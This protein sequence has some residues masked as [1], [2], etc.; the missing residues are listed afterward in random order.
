LSFADRKVDESV[1][2]IHDLAN[3]EIR[4]TEEATSDGIVDKIPPASGSKTV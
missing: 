4:I 3:E 2:E 1:D